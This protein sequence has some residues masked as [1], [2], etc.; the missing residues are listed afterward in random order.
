MPD[1]LPDNEL[2]PFALAILLLL[3]LLL[4]T[5]WIIRSQLPKVV[6]HFE[7]KQRYETS[8]AAPAAYKS[9]QQK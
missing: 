7:F 2:G 3:L 8:N 9:K 5:V 1:R 4:L 6:V